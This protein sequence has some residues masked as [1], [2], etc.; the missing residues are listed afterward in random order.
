MDDNYDTCKYVL[1]TDNS[2]TNHS[3]RQCGNPIKIGATYC[4]ACFTNDTLKKRYPDNKCGV[5]FVP[6]Y[7]YYSANNVCGFIIRDGVKTGVSCIHKSDLCASCIERRQS[8]QSKPLPQLIEKDEPLT[9]LS[10]KIVSRTAQMSTIG[11]IIPA[12]LLPF[13]NNGLIPDIVINPNTIK[14]KQRR[15]KKRVQ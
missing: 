13:D 7:G 12:S 14:R 9:Q 5:F 2:S 4:D 6:I 11:A 8:L 15:M 10:D 1:G 3:P